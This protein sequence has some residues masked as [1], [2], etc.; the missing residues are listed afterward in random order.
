[1]NLRARLIRLA[2]GKPE[3]REKLLPL[4]LAAKPPL[5]EGT[6]YSPTRLYWPDGRMRPMAGDRVWR[7]VPGLYGSGAAYGEAVRYGDQ[8]KILFQR[9]RLPASGAWNVEGD[10][11]VRADSEAAEKKKVDETLSRAE[12]IRRSKEVVEEVARKNRFRP[13]RSIGEVSVGDRV[14]SIRSEGAYGDGDPEKVTVTPFEVVGVYPAEDLFE[15]EGPHGP[16]TSGKVTNWW[17]RG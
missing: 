13:I 12:K 8:I 1:M 2:Y 5:V 11:K 7:L 4:V 14:F 15:I 6:P 3:L 17:R 10:P 9:K 16:T